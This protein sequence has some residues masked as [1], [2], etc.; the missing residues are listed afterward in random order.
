M[1]EPP[2]NVAFMTRIK[3]EP[4]DPEAQHPVVFD[5]LDFRKYLL[6]WFVWKKRVRPAWSQRQ[7]AS[8]GKLAHGSVGNVVSG[9]RHPSPETVEGFLR[10]MVLDAEEAGYFRLLVDLAD[11]DGT[12]AR[13]PVLES[14]FSHPGFERSRT[15]TQDLHDYLDDPLTVVVRELSLFPGFVPDATWLAKRLTWD[16]TPAQVAEALERLGRLG[17]LVSGTL[18]SAEGAAKRLETSAGA[19]GEAMF[20]HHLAVLDLASRLLRK[21]PAESRYYGTAT[22]AVP[23]GRLDALRMRLHQHLRDLI[24]DLDASN[25]APEVLVQIGVQVFP[26]ATWEIADPKP[27]G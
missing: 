11:A 10:A 25:E 27:K 19:Q 24:N 1:A 15:L 3:A 22:V 14:L 8:K 5:Y 23:V 13:Y 21:I 16:V 4:S 6:D 18:A 17:L 9:L 20:R 12:E 2:D 7:F 26:L